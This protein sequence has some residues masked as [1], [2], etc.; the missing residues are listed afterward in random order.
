MRRAAALIFPGLLAFAFF[1]TAEAQVV[2]FPPS[3]ASPTPTPSPRPTPEPRAMPCPQ[4]TVQP[5]AARQVKD[6]Q[7][8]AFGVNIA[9]GDPKVQPTILWSTTAGTITEGQGTRR[10]VIDSTG[11]GD[12]PDRELKAEIWVGGYAPECVL[13]ASAAIKVI[14]ASKKFGE[15]G[16]LPAETVSFHL[17]TL[18]EFLSKS[19]DNLY[20]IGYAGRNNERG[21][22]ANALRR[23]RAELSDAGI[24][25][26][27]VNAVDGGFREEPLF[28]FWIVPQG[29]EP[30]VPTPTLDRRD[31]VYPKAAPPKRP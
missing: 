3:T 2:R 25:P 1:A 12:Q 8:V 18:A 16:D 13:Q 28:D 27:R 5:Q 4:V 29:S 31:I 14:G 11:A 26:R 6:G 10:V 19:S 15:F 21:Y 7:P 9:G 30:P 24:N 17:K 22:A 20:I 23:M